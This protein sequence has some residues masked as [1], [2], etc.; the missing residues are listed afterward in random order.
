MINGLNICDTVLF[1][2]QYNGEYTR[3]SLKS[4]VLIC[5]S[6]SLF[7]TFHRVNMLRETKSWRKSS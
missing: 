4:F 3:H 1:V 6:I 7:I 2:V 5:Y